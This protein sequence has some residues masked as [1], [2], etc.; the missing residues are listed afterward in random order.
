MIWQP[1][2]LIIQVICVNQLTDQASYY[3]LLK[4]GFVLYK[5]NAVILTVIKFICEF[6]KT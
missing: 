3:P 5:F 4:L 6:N 1:P 2:G